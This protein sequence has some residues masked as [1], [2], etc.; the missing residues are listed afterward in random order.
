MP[1]KKGRKLASTTA[2][3][4][5]VEK[6]RLEAIELRSQCWSY[7]AIAET[8]KV[9]KARAHQ[10]V[11]E[12]I[13]HS[14]QEPIDRHVHLAIYR[15]ETAMTQTFPAVAAGDQMAIQNWLAIENRLDKLR[16][17]KGPP[18]EHHVSGGLAHEIKISFVQPGP[19]EEPV[20]IEHLNG[21]NG[22]G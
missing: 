12:A 19:V 14:I 7:A 20:V 13:E 18:E 4:I 6:K 8:L 11:G 3:A 2:R 16:G 5:A 9:S 21:K 1:A 15:A 10:L 22:H 17:I